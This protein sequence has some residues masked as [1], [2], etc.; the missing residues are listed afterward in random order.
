MLSSH[1]CN[2]EVCISWLWLSS[3]VGFHVESIQNIKNRL[4]SVLV[5]HDSDTEQVLIYTNNFSHQSQ[6]CV[7]RMVDWQMSVD[8]FSQCLVSSWF[9]LRPPLLTLTQSWP[10]TECPRLCSWRCDLTPDPSPRP[11]SPPSSSELW[12]SQTHSEED[13]P[14]LKKMRC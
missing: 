8:W 2:W 3:L 10:R 7:W 14:P 9:L 4:D 1:N 11:P 13:Q 6:S 5:K 12:S